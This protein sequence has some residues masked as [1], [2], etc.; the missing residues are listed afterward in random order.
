MK[1][2]VTIVALLACFI[3]G[4]CKHY[5]HNNPSPAL[6]FVNFDS[7]DLNTVVVKSHNTTYACPTCLPVEQTSIYTSRQTFSYDTI[8]LSGSYLPTTARYVIPLDFNTDAS[9]FIPA[10]GKTYY[11][12]GYKF[13]RD[14]WESTNCTNSMSYYLNDTLHTQ[15]MQP[16]MSGIGIIYITK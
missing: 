7:S 5:C 13:N 15:P 6:V 1:K 3:L 14:S 4:S 10:T 2:A 9:I 8:N 12:R 11:F 16:G